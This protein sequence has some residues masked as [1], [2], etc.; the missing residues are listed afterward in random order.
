MCR[1]LFALFALLLTVLA[2]LWPARP[3]AAQTANPAAAALSESAAASSEAPTFEGAG[4]LAPGAQALVRQRFSGWRL[5]WIANVR[6]FENLYSVVYGVKNPLSAMIL[7]ATDNSSGI[8]RILKADTSLFPFDEH[9]SETPPL[10]VRVALAEALVKKNAVPF[11]SVSN[12]VRALQRYDMIRY[13][14]PE[15]REAIINLG[16]RLPKN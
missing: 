16:G 3:T 11:G 8:S 15:Q 4:E 7:T 6:S 9:R 5:E 2:L 10:E 14:S 12:Y 1:I 13:L